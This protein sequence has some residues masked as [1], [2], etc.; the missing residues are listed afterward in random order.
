MKYTHSLSVLSVAAAAVLLAGCGS[1]LCDR[2]AKSTSGKLGTCSGETFDALG[3]K[4]SSAQAS[5]KDN[6]QKVL[7]GMVSCFENLPACK[8]GEE[9]AFSSGKTECYAKAYELSDTCR[10]ALFEGGVVPSTGGGTDAGSGNQQE[11]DR[12]GGG[13]LDLVFVADETSMAVAWTKTQTGGVDHWRLYARNPSDQRL[14]LITVADPNAGYYTITNPGAETT[15][16]LFVVG[17]GPDG[18]PS[19]GTPFGGIP[20]AGS[21]CTQ[22]NQCP[23]DR[24]CDLGTCKQLVCNSN[25]PPQCPVGYACDTVN[26][27]QC[28]RLSSDGGTAVITVDAGEVETQKPFVSEERQ[29][30]LGPPSHRER[31]ISVFAA[32]ADPDVVGIDSARQ[33]VTVQQFGQIYLHV[34]ENRGQTWRT[35]AIDSLGQQAKVTYNRDS[36]QIFVCYTAGS[37]VRVRSTGDFGRSFLPSVAEIALP[38]PTDGGLATPVAECDIAPWRDGGALVVVNE[39]DR[40]ATYV[41]GSGVAVGQRDDVYLNEVTT[42]GGTT[43]VF[44]AQ[45]PVIATLPAEFIVHVAFTG[46]RNLTGG[47]ADRDVYGVYRDPARTGGIFS[48]RQRISGGTFGSQGQILEQTRVQLALE[49]Q[50]GRAAAAFESEEAGSG[51]GPNYQ[52]VYLA[53]FQKNAQNAWQWVTGSDLNIFARNSANSAY[54]VMTDRAPAGQNW[55]AEEP[56]VTFSGNGKGWLTFGAAQFGQPANIYVVGFGLDAT[57]PINLNGKGW[58][59]PPAVKVSTTPVVDLGATSR[60]SGPVISGDAQISTYITFIE[61]VGTG[62]TTPNRPVMLARPQQ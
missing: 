51:G 61:G 11:P 59:L 20:D 40:L 43:T 1:N 19:L 32:D 39:Q 54:V 5:C 23:Q 53:F 9:S 52:S 62:N 30:T 12:D 44:N 21:G 37:A 7:E 8:A 14:P 57:S 41:I 22:N 15:Q 50:T 28:V 48:A 10:E 17:A 36:R 24:V 3:G 25:N 46:T 49:P 34:T 33:A 26:N 29:V 6:D 16:F 60:S 27:F 56:S 13:A 58:F 42:D 18:G 55:N 45:R 35:T 2:S 47:S 31:G 38:M 4:C